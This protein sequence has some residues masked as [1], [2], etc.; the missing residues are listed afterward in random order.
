MEGIRGRGEITCRTCLHSQCMERDRQ[1][2]CKDYANQEGEKN[3]E[4]KVRCI[5]KRPDEQYGH[6]TNISTS[7][8][9]LQKIV[10]GPIETVACGGSSV[11][12]CNEEGKIRGLEPNFIIGIA[13]LQDVVV[14][15]AIVIGVDGDDFCDLPISFDLWKRL[16]KGWGN[17]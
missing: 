15:D 14:G 16:L 17:E 2:P 1:Y 13:P 11:I 5:I 12:I 9:N 7:L 3:M 10:G 6:V 8:K 4:G